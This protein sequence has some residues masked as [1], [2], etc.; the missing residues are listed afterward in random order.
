LIFI[1]AW[2][3][4]A[5]DAIDLV[6]AAHNDGRALMHFTGLYI[7]QALSRCGHRPSATMAPAWRAEYEFSC[8]QC[9]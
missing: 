4:E 8:I 9:R 1:C 2:G 5:D 7:E 6:G 3:E